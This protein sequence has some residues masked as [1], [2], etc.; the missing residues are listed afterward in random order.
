M[1]YL[2]NIMQE[3]ESQILSTETPQKWLY[4]FMTKQPVSNA[5]CDGVNKLCLCGFKGET[6]EEKDLDKCINNKSK[7]N[8]SSSVAR[9]IGIHLGDHSQKYKSEVISF[10]KN[11]KDN[12]QKYI[13]YLCFPF[14]K[15]EFNADLLLM[16]EDK[17]VYKYLMGQ[18]SFD[19]SLQFFN[20]DNLDVFDLIIYKL[21]LKQDFNSLIRTSNL[22]EN[23]IKMLTNFSNAIKR[24]TTNRYNK[25]SG[26]V[27]E[28]EY[29]VQD[30]LFS[31]FKF[32]FNDVVREDPL[33]KRAGSHS[34]IDICFPEQKLYIEVK[35][36]K[37]TDSDEKKIIEELKKDMFDYDQDFVKDL[38]I[39]IY[40]PYDKIND[41]D[42][43]SEFEKNKSHN[44]KCFVV[45]Q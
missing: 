43:F 27:I 4:Q 29:D 36:L 21:L 10:Y 26:I 45:I 18:E 8:Y 37:K 13:F 35:M 5:E 40:D 2:K 34:I 22:T 7:L 12:K 33:P 28:Q 24:I 25:K 15:E 17:T 6:L 32:Y 41:K 9:F 16:R 23:I 11:L 20:Y 1:V 38:I 14:L 42:A 31:Y 39:F 19:E 3:L 44:F 30:I